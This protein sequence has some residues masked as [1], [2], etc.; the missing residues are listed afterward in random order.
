MSKETI[1]IK[2][3]FYMLCYAWN[4][5][6]IKDSINVSSENIKD[7][8]NLLGRIF[9]YCVGKLIRQGFHRCYITTEDELATLK[10]KVLLSNTINKSSMVKKKL[11]CQ[12][13]EFTANNLFN[14]I[15]KYTLSSLIKNPTIDNSIK[16]DIKSKLSILQIS[17]KQNRI[18]IIYKNYDLIEIILYTNY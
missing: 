17:V 14:Q 3:L 2:N 6:S 10:G 5:L 9:S 8:Y 18:K 12:F 7:S 1:P 15:V 11:C 13:D 4:V 16:K